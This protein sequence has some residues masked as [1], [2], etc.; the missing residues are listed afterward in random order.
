M[1][2]TDAT[3]D[4]AAGQDETV[5]DAVVSSERLHY[6]GM[7][8]APIDDGTAATDTLLPGDGPTGRETGRVEDIVGDYAHDDDDTPLI[9]RLQPGT[10]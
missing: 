10:E 6:S 7:T 5:T 8:N 2:T 4:D 3:P 9:K 1:S